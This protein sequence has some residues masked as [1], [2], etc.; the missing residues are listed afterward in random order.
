MFETNFLGCEPTG[1]AVSIFMFIF[2][3]LSAIR[4]DSNVISSKYISP[5]QESLA[6][7]RRTD[8]NFEHCKGYLCTAIIET[9]P[10]WLN[11]DPHKG[12]LCTAI[13]EIDPY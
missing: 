12:Y 11:V 9:D 7:G 5:D 1:P 6:I 2:K 3:I 13:I 4:A 10:Y 8:V